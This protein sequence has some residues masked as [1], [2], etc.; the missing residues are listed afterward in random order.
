MRKGRLSALLDAVS[1]VRWSNLDP[2]WVRRP[3]ENWVDAPIFASGNF[4]SWE[5]VTWFLAV[6]LEFLNLVGFIPGLWGVEDRCE[7]LVG[8]L[9]RYLQVGNGLEVSPGGRGISYIRRF[10]GLLQIAEMSIPQ[11]G[12]A[13]QV[14][15]SATRK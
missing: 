7:R 9:R 8:K 13:N 5:L 10:A 14:Q 15:V 12:P 3:L 1:S 6:R 2:C 11:G 4:V